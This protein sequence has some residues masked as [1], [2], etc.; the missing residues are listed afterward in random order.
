MAMGELLRALERGASD[1]ARAIVAAS[2]AEVAAIDAEAARACAER[3]REDRTAITASLEPAAD[4]RVAAAA[5]AARTAVLD[6]R[7]AMVARV[8]AATRARL[9]DLVAAQAETLGPRLVADALDAA[10]PA[11]TGVL[12]C[13]PALEP[14]ARAAAPP[15]LRVIVDPAVTGAVIEL[16]AITIDATLDALLDRAWPELATIAAGSA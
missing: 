14:F 10:G 8:Q 6:A 15:T 3:R 1:E 12:R 4:A 7:A 11:P 16:G 2:A 5:R 13:A 9:P